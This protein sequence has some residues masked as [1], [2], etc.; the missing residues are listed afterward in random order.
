MAY[1]FVA[2]QLAWMLRP[3]VGDPELPVSLFRD[4]L[5]Q[6]PYVTVSRTI[7]EALRP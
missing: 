6:N 4:S 7:L 1:A 3:V 5:W 2:I